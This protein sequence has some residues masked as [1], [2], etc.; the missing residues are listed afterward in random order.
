MPLIH[1]IDK[2]NKIDKQLCT[3]VDD[4]ISLEYLRSAFP[5]AIGLEFYDS[6]HQLY[7]GFV[8]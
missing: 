3:A 8:P 2:K 7:T 4:T 6:N 1:V 5:G